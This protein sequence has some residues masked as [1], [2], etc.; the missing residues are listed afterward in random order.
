MLGML[1]NDKER[2]ELD[3]MLRKE[4]DEML[5]DLNDTRLESEIRQAIAVRYKTVFRMYARF[6]SPK[7]LSRYVRNGKIPALKNG[8]TKRL[9]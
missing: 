2:K 8:E 6:A 4:L 3:Y 7:E 1:L 9:T 5:L